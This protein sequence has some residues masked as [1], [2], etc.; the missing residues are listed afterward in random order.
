[1]AS[2]RAKRTAPNLLNVLR[3]SLDIYAMKALI[4]SIFSGMVQFLYSGSAR[5]S[6]HCPNMVLLLIA[7]TSF[8]NPL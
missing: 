8:L 1:M 2:S 4:L 7:K 5:I 3:S 6:F